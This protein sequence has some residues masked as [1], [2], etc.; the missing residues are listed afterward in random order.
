MKQLPDIHPTLRIWPPPQRDLPGTLRR[1][2]IAALLTC[3]M[4]TALAWQYERQANDAVRREAETV[5]GH[6]QNYTAV[7]ASCLNGRGF[8]DKVTG[9]VYIC[10]KPSEIRFQ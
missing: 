7:L 3:T 8:Y 5:R 1:A 4:L 9:N 2:V 6:L 10:S